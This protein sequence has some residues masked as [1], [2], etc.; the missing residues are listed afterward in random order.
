MDNNKPAV[1]LLQYFSSSEIRTQ[2]LNKDNISREERTRLITQ[3]LPNVKNITKPG[4]KPI[5]QIEL[6]TKWHLLVSDE[7]SVNIFPIPPK[8]I[9]K[10]TRKIKCK[11]GEARK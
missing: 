7:F 8:K 11:E 1:L 9:S 5:K 4:M 10:N 2:D 3:A 6:A